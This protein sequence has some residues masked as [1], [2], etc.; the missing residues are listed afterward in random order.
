MGWSLG[1]A[2]IGALVTNA[3][4]MAIETRLGRFAEP[5]TIIESDHGVQ[6]GSLAFTQRARDSGLLASMGSIGDCHDSSMVEAFW[7]RMRVELLNRKQWNT[8]LELTKAMFEYLEI[9]QNRKRR[10]GLPGW[11]TP[12]AFERN[13]I[14]TVA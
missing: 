11:L 4:R 14:I 9:W 7:S 10:H 8:S 13:R 5:G 3:L 2:Q 6:G 12:V 1:S